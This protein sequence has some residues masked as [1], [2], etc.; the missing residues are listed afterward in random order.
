MRKSHRTVRGYYSCELLQHARKKLLVVLK[1]SRSSVAD[2][3]IL[4]CLKKEP[5]VAIIKVGANLLASS[6]Q[7]KDTCRH[8]ACVTENWVAAEVFVGSEPS[9]SRNQSLRQKWHRWNTSP[10]KANQHQSSSSPLPKV[11][12][13][14]YWDLW[15]TKRAEKKEVCHHLPV[16]SLR[17]IE[18]TTEPKLGDLA[19]R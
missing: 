10:S 17:I 5:V 1:R 14:S 13:R 12:P 3:P 7:D 16:V 9:M 4:S 15:S 11:L 6:L 2:E 18:I 8:Y 19:I